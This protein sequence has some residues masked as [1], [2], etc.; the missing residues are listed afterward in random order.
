MTTELRAQFEADCFAYYQRLK[1]SGWAHS[2]EGDQTPE[3][4]FWRR[5]TNPEMYGIHQIEAAWQGYQMRAGREAVGHQSERHLRRL[6][7]VRCGI[8][9]LYTDDGEASGSEHGV[10]IDFIREPVA[11]IDAKLRALNAARCVINN[12]IKP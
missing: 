3:S 2:A 12:W 9:G 11:D 6:L 1:A 4:L 8:P 5:E 7:A 10:H